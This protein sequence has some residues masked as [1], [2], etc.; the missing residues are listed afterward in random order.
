MV[1][2]VMGV[3]LEGMNM[4]TMGV[5]VKS[6]IDLNPPLVTNPSDQ[7]PLRG[8]STATAVSYSILFFSSKKNS[9]TCLANS[10]SKN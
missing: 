9:V 8:Y 4:A 5:F 10:Y 2:P 3:G 6:R 7:I 1:Y